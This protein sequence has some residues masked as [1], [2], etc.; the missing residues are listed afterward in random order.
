MRRTII[1]AALLVGA[2]TYATVAI[3]RGE[4]P[5]FVTVYEP[6]W[7]IGVCKT[8]DPL[9]LTD[10]QRGEM[11]LS[12]DDM[13]FDTDFIA[14]PFIVKHEGTFFMFYEVW[15]TNATKGV[16]GVAESTDGVTFTHTGIALDEPYHLAYPAVHEVDGTHYMIPDASAS[17]TV[18][19]YRATGFPLEWEY[20]TT[21]VDERLVDATVF[22][23]ADR[24]WMLGTDHDGLRLFH[25]PELEGQW[26]EHPASPVTTNTTHSRSAG[27]V[28]SVDGALFRFA[29]DPVPTYGSKV[30][31]IWISQLSTEQY[32]ETVINRPVIEADGK[33]WNKLGMHQVSAIQDGDAWVVAVD[34]KTEG[35]G[36][37][38]MCVRCYLQG[39]I[40]K[41]N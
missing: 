14:D 9:V 16:I 21:L 22:Q 3:S 18:K 26:I 38:T 2:A 17:N 10:C 31:A 6:E 30:R 20:V 27:G 36:R 24:Y 8:H 39:A 40:A 35:K 11:T 15:P 28:V 41:K 7:S 37:R 1:I 13:G 33:G 32:A 12:K 25:S 23:H 4:I 34:G 19:L 29:Q 5:P